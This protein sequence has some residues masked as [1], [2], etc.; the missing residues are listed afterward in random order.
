MLALRLVLATVV[1]LGTRAVTPLETYGA[2]CAKIPS[3]TVPADPE[4]LHLRAGLFSQSVTRVAAH[5]AAAGGAARRHTHTAALNRFADRTGFEREAFRTGFR[6][7]SAAAT[8]RI[9]RHTVH[10]P[11]ATAPVDWDP[12]VG[13]AANQIDQ[14]ACGSCWSMSASLVLSTSIF[15]VSNETVHLSP[16]QAVDCDTEVYG[17]GG[18]FP[19]SAVRTDLAAG[20]FEDLDAYPYTA[21][22]GPCAFNRSRTVPAAAAV[23]NATMVEPA[24]QDA[25]LLA[26]LQDGPVSVCFDCADD[27]MDYAG[28][29]Y[30]GDCSSDPAATDHCVVVV[31]AGL[32]R[33]SGRPY[34]R[35]R[36][37]WG[38]DWGARGDFFLPAD[39]NKCGLANW[40]MTINITA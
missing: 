3:C 34:Y 37:S 24:G 17:C 5:N 23:A 28:G 2:W 25:T 1:A 16:Q 40:M 8:A 4:E 32:L 10:G 30:D 36:N 27:L 13:A 6:A 18:G 14:G 7:P 19:W 15:L 21:L 31:G 38:L 20:G 35:V 39:T 33:G 26:V 22:D 29:L 11:R 9:P 12:V